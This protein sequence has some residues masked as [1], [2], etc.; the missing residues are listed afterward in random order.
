MFQ[1]WEL[2]GLRKLD[3][4]DSASSR[5]G[6]LEIGSKSPLSFA[7]RWGGLHDTFP[8]RWSNFLIKTRTVLKRQK[9]LLKWSGGL[10]C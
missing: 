6:G 1:K 5:H 9:L 4:T 7:L 10:S 8:I 3:Q 2:G